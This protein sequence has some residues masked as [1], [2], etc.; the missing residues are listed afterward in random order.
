M[1]ESTQQRR[2]LIIKLLPPSSYAYSPGEEKSE[3]LQHI[4]ARENSR[5][6]AEGSPRTVSTVCELKN[7]KGYYAM[8]IWANAEKPSKSSGADSR[9]SRTL[10]KPQPQQDILKTVSKSEKC[11]LKNKRE[12]ENVSLQCKKKEKKRKTKHTIK[13]DRYRKID[14]WTI[15]KRLMVRRD[16]WALN[17]PLLHHNSEAITKPKRMN[18]V[19]IK[20]KLKNWGYSEV[21]EF[22]H[23]INNVFSYALG[24]PPRSEIHIIARRISEDF[25]VSW[26]TLVKK[27]M[28][29]EE[30]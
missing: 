14:C 22:E 11:K 3:I 25:K 13:M 2:K 6:I 8:T 1:A 9:M 17:K 27:W 16:V 20:S 28:R 30:D 23:D 29:E 15:L 19:D 5:A 21:D 12:G 10:T 18:L 7:K 24:Y 4:Y 26:K